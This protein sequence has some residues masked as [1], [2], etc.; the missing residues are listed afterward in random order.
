MFLFY[1]HKILASLIDDR[2][3]LRAATRTMDGCQESRDLAN[4]TCSSRTTSGSLIIIN[5][6]LDGCDMIMVFCHNSANVEGTS[7]M[8]RIG[9]TLW[10]AVTFRFSREQKR[11]Y[12]Q[13]TG[14]LREQ[15]THQT[16]CSHRMINN[17]I[18]V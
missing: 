11:K 1:K 5:L 8:G 17:H 6:M 2:A 12:S 13:K 16:D 15:P 14:V 7:T 3:P 18:I 9:L 4:A 10:L